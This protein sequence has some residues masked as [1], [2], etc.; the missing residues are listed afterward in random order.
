[1]KIGIANRKNQII[2]KTLIAILMSYKHY[3]ITNNVPRETLKMI[4]YLHFKIKYDKLYTC[5][6]YIV[7]WSGPEGSSHINPYLCALFYWV[8]IYE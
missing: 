2:L 4:F 8:I 6:K 5:N 1:M 7:T 3:R